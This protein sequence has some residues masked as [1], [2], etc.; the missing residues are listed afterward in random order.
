[1]SDQMMPIE[2]HYAN[3]E[4]MARAQQALQDVDAQE[5]TAYDGYVV[6]LVERGTIE[7]VASSGLFVTP[8]Y[9]IEEE[10][11]AGLA[12]EVDQIGKY[13]PHSVL[14]GPQAELVERFRNLSAYVKLVPADQIEEI[15]LRS[16]DSGQLQTKSVPVFEKLEQLSEPRIESDTRLDGFSYVGLER[17]AQM[18]PELEEQLPQDAYLV[19]LAGSLRPQWVERLAALGVELRI[20]RS[21]DTYTALLDSYQHSEVKA[22]DFVRAVKRYGLSETLSKEFQ[23]CLA[24]ASQGVGLEVTSQNQEPQTIEVTLHRGRDLEKVVGMIQASTGEKVEEAAWRQFRLKAKLDSPMLSALANLP[25]VAQISTYETPSLY[26]DRVRELIGVEKVAS[27]PVPFGPL[28]GGGEVVG[29]LDSGIDESH[30]DLKDQIQ[31]A[32]TFRS[33]T[34]DDR[35]G[36]G[37]HVAGIIAGA[38]KSSGGRFR[39]VAPKAKL[40]TVGIVAPNQK[41]DLPVNLGELLKIPYDKGARIINLSWGRKLS[42][43]YES[44]ALSIDRFVREHPDALIVIAAGNEGKAPNGQH[45]LSTLGSP[46]SA[47]NA[48]T[49]GASA[50][51]RPDP[52]VWGDRNPGNFPRPPASEEAVGGNADLTAAMSSRGPTDY[53]SI[54]PDLLAPGTLIIAPRASGGNGKAYPGFD[55]YTEK[56]GTSMACPAVAGAAAL[57]RQHLRAAGEANP[58]AALL[59]SLLI[60]SCKKVSAVQRPVNVMDQ[61]GF[62]DFDQG[63]G[64]VDLRNIIPHDETPTNYRT[65]WVDVANGSDEGLTSG[66]LVDSADKTTHRY[67]VTMPAVVTS[68]LKI[69]LAFTDA[70]GAYP[71]NKLNLQVIESG[72]SRWAGNQDHHFTD[73]AVFPGL[74]NPDRSNTVEQVCVDAPKPD[75]VYIIKV[76]ARNTLIPKQGYALAVCGQMKEKNINNS[77][78]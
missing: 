26:C 23:Q 22:L 25:E 63:H 15:S 24:T 75:T 73:T 31:E 74:S 3:K 32:L 17:S 18:E 28:D 20:R 71:Q 76:T 27:R 29:V 66:Q 2:V 40:I 36:H 67:K 54:K 12:S 8:G 72:G 70:P 48:L 44:G 50:T 47:K 57:L 62:P 39:G 1:M 16:V 41:L 52:A 77:D 64:R 69:V 33:G 60:A 37:T 59:K 61:I 13:F 45:E 51:D 38:G 55:A 9:D 6:G 7:D 34:A 11:S 35:I 43:D 42:G 56:T 30:T 68:Q 14:E 4:E 5:I 10:S 53:Q 58:S 49:V 21:L 65:V 46:A 19:R 78:T